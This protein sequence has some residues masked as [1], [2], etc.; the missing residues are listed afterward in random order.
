MDKISIVLILGTAREGNVTQNVARYILGSLGKDESLAVE[1]V[2]VKDYPQTHTLS[3]WDEKKEELPYQNICAEADAFVIVS[4]EY[5]HGYPG[6]LKLFLDSMYDEYKY[7]PFGICGVSDGYFGGVRMVD[8][9][10]PV[11]VEFSGVP[12]KSSLHFPNSPDLFDDE[13]N[14]KDASVFADRIGKF[15]NELMWYARTL[16]Y[17]RNNIKH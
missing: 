14:M 8:H 13:G 9:I 16:K 6:E 11:L 10:K 4:P 5:N 12:I 7:K 2:D 3:P 15:K 17:G 1:M